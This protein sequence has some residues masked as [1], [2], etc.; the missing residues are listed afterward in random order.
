MKQI[1]LVALKV[2]I[3]DEIFVSWDRGCMKVSYRGFAP[4]RNVQQLYL[5]LSKRNVRFHRRQSDK[6]A[7]FLAY[8]L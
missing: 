5:S 4:F 3:H 7:T 6:N 2:Q 8:L 1:Y